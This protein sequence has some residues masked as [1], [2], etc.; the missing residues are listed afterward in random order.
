MISMAD[1][2]LEIN[3]VKK[4]IAEQK[5][6]KELHEEEIERARLKRLGKKYKKPAAKE[7][8]SLNNSKADIQK[9]DQYNRADKRDNRSVSPMLMGRDT[10]TNWVKNDN[11]KIN[12]DKSPNNRAK[13]SQG[14]VSKQRN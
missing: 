9:A 3:D 6:L 2:K 11:K 1:A 13:S 14:H 4:Q 8:D 10:K 7:K 12:L 5:R